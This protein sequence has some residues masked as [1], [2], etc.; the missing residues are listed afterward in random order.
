MFNLPEESDGETNYHIVYLKLPGSV[1]CESTQDLRDDIDAWL[2]TNDVGDDQYNSFYFRDPEN[3]QEGDWY[4]NA[5]TS[6]K[7]ICYCFADR[8]HALLFKLTFK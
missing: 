3:A 8:N 7:Y 4:H 1:W 5:V 2:E 6:N